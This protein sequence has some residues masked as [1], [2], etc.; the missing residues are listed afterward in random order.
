MSKRVAVDTARTRMIN[1]RQNG[2]YNWSEV[3]S[4][5]EYTLLTNR[6]TL[7]DRSN[8]IIPYDFDSI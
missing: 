8:L 3:L 4:E 2:E 5:Q 1:T 6:V 7:P